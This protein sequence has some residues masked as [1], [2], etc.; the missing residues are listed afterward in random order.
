M[1]RFVVLCYTKECQI[2]FG[3]NIR[4][5]RDES[6]DKFEL[7][8]TDVW[9]NLDENYKKIAML[10]LRE[11]FKESNRLN[12]LSIRDNNL[13]LTFDYSKNIITSEIFKLLMDF[14]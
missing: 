12:E 7:K 2:K 11:L 14:C 5:N 1:I 9:Q 13:S 6:M 10:H 3:S 4:C 8:K